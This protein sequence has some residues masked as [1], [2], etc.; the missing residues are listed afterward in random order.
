MIRVP[1]EPVTIYH[2]R[3]VDT[4]AHGNPV[5][6]WPEPGTTVDGCAVAPRSSSEPDEIGRDAVIT[7]I[8][9]YLPPNT[10]VTPT[11]RLRARG[12]VYEVV[13]EPGDWRN[14]FTGGQPW[15]IEVACQRVE[16]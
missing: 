9:V 12:T 1:G 5:F 4:D 16:G 10:V 13:G 11:D 14:P 15:G 8:T 7:G 3:Q 6:G 2:R